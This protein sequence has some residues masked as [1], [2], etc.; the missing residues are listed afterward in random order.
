MI[1]VF[2]QGYAAALLFCMGIA[3]GLLYDLL[4]RLRRGRILSHVLDGVFV[5][6][7]A[8]L[9]ALGVLLSAN[10]RMRAF[11]L[12]FDALGALLSA[13]AFRPIFFHRRRM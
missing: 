5:L 11:Y 8:A 6:L 2:S 3:T 7:A 13:W 4:T 1:D 12:L 10:G 9:L